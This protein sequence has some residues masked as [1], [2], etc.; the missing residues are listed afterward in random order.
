[1]T[2]TLYY[3]PGACSFS[4]HVALREAGL[5][6]VLERVDLRTKKT[7]SG[8][9]FAAMNA[10][11]YVPALRLP[12]GELLT[13]G[14]AIV[15]WIADRAPEKNLAFEPGTLERA[16]VQEWLTFIGTELHKS[17]SPLFDRTASDDAKTAAKNRIAKRFAFTADHLEGKSFL[18]GE[19]FTVADGYLLT[20][21]QWTTFVGIDLEAWPALAA[22]RARML[23]RASVK[24]ALAAERPSA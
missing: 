23:E 3:S 8:D 9:D 17:F 19:R 10:K 13:E 16:R 22:F 20:V 15:Q 5:P 4:P 11:G 1:M 6:F 21:L 7:A 2:Y 24:E 12:S 18:V 14:P